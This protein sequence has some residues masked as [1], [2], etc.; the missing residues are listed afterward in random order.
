MGDVW[1]FEMDAGAE[2]CRARFLFQ[3][4]FL[5]YARK[6]S[7]IFLIPVLGQMEA[8]LG[9]VLRRFFKSDRTP[10][11]PYP[12]LLCRAW[13]GGKGWLAA[14]AIAT[15]LF[16]PIDKARILCYNQSSLNEKRVFFT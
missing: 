7:D 15:L 12:A 4:D 6:S 8:A 11:S 5:A 16:C 10:V 13:S 3:D 14:P 2:D 1:S 9:K